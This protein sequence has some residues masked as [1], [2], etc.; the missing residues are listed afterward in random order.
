MSPIEKHFQ[1]L[2]EIVAKVAKAR[3]SLASQGLSDLSVRQCE[4]QEIIMSEV[5]A[6]CQKSLSVYLE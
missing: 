5:L 1:E 4:V 6:G 2:R 3:K